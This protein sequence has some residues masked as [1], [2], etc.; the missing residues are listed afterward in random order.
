[1]PD[2]IEANEPAATD[3]AATGLAAPTAM[4]PQPDQLSAAL[5]HPG[6]LPQPSQAR[7]IAPVWHT[8]ILILGILAFSIWGSKSGA[9]GA[10]NPLAPVQSAGKA[11]ADGTNSVRLI[12]YSLTGTLEL[13][14]V[15][16]VAFGLR[17]RK[18]PFSA[19]RVKTALTQ[20]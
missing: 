4:Q 15:V 18:I 2:D 17:L 11:A 1:M 19:E 13:L 20:A 10:I 3:F 7:S 6:P 14:V 5:P 12:R 8:V 16:W 9:A